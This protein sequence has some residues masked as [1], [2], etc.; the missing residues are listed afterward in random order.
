[1]ASSGS[2]F[3]QYMASVAKNWL[4]VA[5]C[6]SVLEVETRKSDLYQSLVIMGAMI[7]VRQNDSC[8]TVKQTSC[9]LGVCLFG[10]TTLRL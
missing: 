4:I 2:V 8:T 10:S 1:M 3:V 7:K 9:V 6:R 5:G